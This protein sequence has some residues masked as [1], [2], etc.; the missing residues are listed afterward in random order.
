MGKILMIC[1]KC[2]AD[3]TEPDIDYELLRNKN[4]HLLGKKVNFEKK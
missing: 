4:I 3:G 2:L 1:R